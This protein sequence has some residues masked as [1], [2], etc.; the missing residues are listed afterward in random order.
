MLLTSPI[1]FPN[2]GI[3]VDPSPVA[4]TI[5][6][7]EIYWY[8]I[9]IACGFLLAVLYMIYRAKTFGLTQ[10]DVLD[11]VLWAV[12]IG[13]VCA[14]LSAHRHAQRPGKCVLSGFAHSRLC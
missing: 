8:G 13:V 10:D 12:P 4:F 2:L 3:T 7:K 11:L 1:S 9:I 5:F 14:R 6:G